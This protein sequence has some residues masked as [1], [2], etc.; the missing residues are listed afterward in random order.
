MSSKSEVMIEL[1]LPSED[2]YERMKAENLHELINS[3]GGL[4]S[5]GR[6][7]EDYYIVSQR[8]RK[9]PMEDFKKLAQD[10]LNGQE[11]I[12]VTTIGEEFPEDMEV[13]YFKKDDMVTSWIDIRDFLPTMQELTEYKNRNI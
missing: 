1:L 6:F 5:E 2:G 9:I 7:D 10:F 4:L 8:T 11:V 3:I 12:R 13:T